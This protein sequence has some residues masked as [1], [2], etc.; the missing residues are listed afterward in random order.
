MTSEPPDQCLL[1]ALAE[2]IAE[3]H[4]N[5]KK[6]GQLLNETENVLA[7]NHDPAC[8]FKPRTREE[9]LQDAIME[10]IYEL[11]ESRKSFKSKRLESL[12]K[13][14]TTVLVDSK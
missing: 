10:A 13:K 2:K 6:V 12:R 11:D 14:L 9:I 5:L 4:A 8:L 1:K 7:F 3:L